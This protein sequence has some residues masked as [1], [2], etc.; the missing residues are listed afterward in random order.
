EL[1]AASCREAERQLP[2]LLADGLARAGVEARELRVHAAPRRLALV[3]A[4]LPAE[5]AARRTEVR[6]P[7]ADAPEQARAG[8]ARKYGL[9]AAALTAREG[10][11]WAVSE[12]APTPV[13][14]LAQPLLDGILHGLQFSKSVRWDDGRF[15]RPVRWLV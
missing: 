14:E 3:A 10:F 13:G 4:G 11:L 1:P 6:G 2:G 15:A 9:D 5:R 12:G 7:R 8:F